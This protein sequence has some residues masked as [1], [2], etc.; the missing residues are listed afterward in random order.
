MTAITAAQV[1]LMNSNELAARLGVSPSWVRH[2]VTAR[3]IPITWVGKHARFSE[4]DYE[5]ILAAGREPARN[6]PVAT[7]PPTYPPSDPGTGTG[8]GRDTNQPRP[9]KS[10]ARR[11]G[12]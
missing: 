6:G 5:Q 9:K 3:R 12:T 4:A 2:A 10:A 11:R 7:H 8:P 1:P